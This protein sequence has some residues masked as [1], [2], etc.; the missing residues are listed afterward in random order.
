MPFQI[1]YS[2]QATE[3]MTVTELEEILSDARVGNKA[4]NI[5]GALI[6]VDG[7]FF[8]ILE[9]DKAVVRKLMA[10]IARDSR[11]KFV[12]VFYDAE[13]DERVFESWSMA[14][15]NST[16]EQM[17]IWA[18]LP[19]TTT[20]EKLL[21]GVKRNPDRVPLMLISILNALIEQDE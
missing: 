12:K 2:S 20:V 17:S 10:S 11:H 13:V 8:Q 3:L 6:Y 18:G 5:T 16:P 4:R 19:D 7:V 1:I 15:L 21:T 9:G 14:Y